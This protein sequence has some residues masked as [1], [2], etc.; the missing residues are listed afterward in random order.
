M[1]IHEALDFARSEIDRAVERIQ[2]EYRADA[3]HRGLSEI[4]IASSLLDH[5]VACL[6]H[7]EA[8]LGAVAAMFTATYH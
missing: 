1:T 3:L 4:D 5:T 8:A 7:R 2:E 6:A